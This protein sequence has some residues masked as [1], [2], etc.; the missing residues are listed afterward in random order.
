MTEPILAQAQAQAERE[1]YPRSD[2]TQ[3]DFAD[4]AVWELLDRNHQ[5]HE[6]VTVTMD[7]NVRYH[8]VECE[9]DGLTWPC[10]VRRQLEGMDQPSRLQYQRAL[11]AQE[12]RE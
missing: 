3:V 10:P 1:L 4:P 11:P 6:V 8:R 12:P 9:K 2:F 5:P 7:G